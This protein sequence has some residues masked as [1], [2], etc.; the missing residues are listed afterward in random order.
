[1]LRQACAEYERIVERQR[2]LIDLREH[3][4]R[5]MGL[6]GGVQDGRFGTLN[7]AGQAAAAQ[8]A[9]AGAVLLERLDHALAHRPESETE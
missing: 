1:V 5:S 3:H 8:L 7:P 2:L 9:E 4:A 6:V